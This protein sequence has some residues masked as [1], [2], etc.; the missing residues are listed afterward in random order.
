MGAFSSKLDLKVRHFYPDSLVRHI[1]NHSQFLF[2][3]SHWHLSPLIETASTFVSFKSK[4]TTFSS[5]QAVMNQKKKKTQVLLITL[6]MLMMSFQHV[7]APLPTAAETSSCIFT[8][9][10]VLSILNIMLFF[11]HRDSSA[12]LCHI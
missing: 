8:I 6:S 9:T 11:M 3:T 7:E 10:T 4:Q 5:H 2:Q 1:S 12:A